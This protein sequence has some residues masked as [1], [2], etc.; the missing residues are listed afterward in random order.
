MLVLLNN[1]VQLY[2][3][4]WKSNRLI[5]KAQKL[6]KNEEIY[7]LVFHP[8]S[9]THFISFGKRH[10]ILWMLENNELNSK[11]TFKHVR[12]NPMINCL[13]F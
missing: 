1:S 5:T 9:D 2:Y 8:D 7:G 11:K 4:D 13:C 12:F 10:L 6:L 3:L